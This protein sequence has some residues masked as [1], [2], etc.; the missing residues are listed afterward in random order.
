MPD[1]YHVVPYLGQLCMIYNTGNNNYL[2]MLHFNRVLRDYSKWQFV[3]AYLPYLS[4]DFT[5]AL[6]SFNMILQGKVAKFR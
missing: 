4:G 5:D 3:L 6:Q 1:H 2:F